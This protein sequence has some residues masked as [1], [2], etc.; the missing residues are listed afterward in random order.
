MSKGF[1]RGSGLKLCQ[2]SATPQAKADNLKQEKNRRLTA[3]SAAHHRPQN[4]GFPRNT[5]NMLCSQSALFCSKQDD[6]AAL[7]N[8]HW[9]TGSAHPYPM[10]TQQISTKAQINKRALF[11]SKFLFCPCGTT[12]S[13]ISKQQPQCTS[14]LKRAEPVSTHSS[15]PPLPAK[16]PWRS[17]WIG[18]D[19]MESPKGP[20]RCIFGGLNLRMSSGPV[21]VSSAQDREQPSVSLAKLP[22][23][24]GVHEHPYQPQRKAVV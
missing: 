14:L 12:S 16:E 15:A 23:N 24:L 10:S 19:T 4:E 2:S 1:T 9:E 3:Q 11:T 17:A 7:T 13:F 21:R 6:M 20:L 18:G 8:H 5:G 22:S